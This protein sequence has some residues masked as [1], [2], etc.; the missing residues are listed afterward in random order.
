MQIEIKKKQDHDFIVQTVR[1][2][3]EF[4]KELNVTNLK[5]DKQT[6]KDELD[7][8]RFLLDSALTLTWEDGTTKGIIGTLH[9]F[10]E[11]DV[12]NDGESGQLIKAYWYTL[13]ENDKVELVYKAFLEQY[14]KCQI[15]GVKIHGS[16]NTKRER[17][18][19]VSGT[20]SNG[21]ST[22]TSPDIALIS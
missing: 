6:F 8:L 16:S 18:K 9:A 15:E 4:F 21:K 10:N 2:N 19:V 11:R 5:F 1:K 14:F 20:A 3:K 13:P 12:I 17:K 22:A 7:W